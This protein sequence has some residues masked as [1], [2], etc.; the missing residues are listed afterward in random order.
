M[1]T[2]KT[3]VILGALLLAG[4]TAPSFPA[5]TEEAPGFQP[6]ASSAALKAQSRELRTNIIERKQKIAVFEVMLTD[7][8][9]RAAR[10]QVPLTYL[11]NTNL[12]PEVQTARSVNDRLG[13][14]VRPS[15]S[16]ASPSAALAL[17]PP[18]AKLS[19]QKSKK[20]LAKK[21]KKIRRY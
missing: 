4:C 19:T 2:L 8:E 1:T 18:K 12:L 7:V 17:V 15:L 9:R 16:A 6:T 13:V 11:P 21:K 20:P 5:K 3:T 14:A 10:A